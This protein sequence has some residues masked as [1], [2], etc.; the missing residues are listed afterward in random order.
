MHVFI[1]EEKKNR[2]SKTYL[3]GNTVLLL[4]IEEEAAEV[5]SSRSKISLLCREILN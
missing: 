2:W 1:L 3:K 4:A 5:E